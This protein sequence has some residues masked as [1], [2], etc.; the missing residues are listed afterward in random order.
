[1]KARTAYKAEHA[2]HQLQGLI[3]RQRFWS[4]DLQ[5]SPRMGNHDQGGDVQK[6]YSHAC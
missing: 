3:V 4:V 1:M 2:A 5:G 6:E